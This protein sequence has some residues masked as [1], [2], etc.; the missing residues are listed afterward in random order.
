MTRA[1]AEHLIAYHRAVFPQL[2]TAKDKVVVIWI[3]GYFLDSLGKSDANDYNVYDDA[4]IVVSPT[5]FK[6]FN[7]NCDPSFVRHP[8]TGK[9]LAKLNL[10]VYPFY[11]GKHKGEYA[12]FRAFPE[13]V[14]LPCTREA[15]AATCQYVNGHYGGENPESWYV[16]WSEAC[17][18][19][20]KSQFKNEFQPELY[21]EMTKCGQQTVNFI[22]IEKVQITGAEHYKSGN[23]AIIPRELKVE[24]IIATSAIEHFGNAF[25]IPQSEPSENVSEEI[26][27]PNLFEEFAEPVVLEIKDDLPQITDCFKS[28]I[29]PI[30]GKFNEA[31]ETVRRGMDVYETAIKVTSGKK[32]SFFIQILGLIFSAVVAAFGFVKENWKLIAI[33]VVGVV[34]LVIT[35][36]V[37]FAVINHFKM[38]YAADPDK[39]NVE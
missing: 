15:R 3:R 11:K 17:L 31:Q 14:I 2:F 8:K 7:A 20:P 5:Y 19:I 23:N 9:P 29:E 25:S 26:Q 18:T 22:L 16:T 38:K 1:E 24:N 32:T 12:A 10:G 35:I 39:Y 21:A 34:F 36:S 30:L 4:A 33:G 13:G 37:I 27:S 6:T 28:P